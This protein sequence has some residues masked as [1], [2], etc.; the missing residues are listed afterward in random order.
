MRSR[1]RFAG[2]SAVAVAAAVVGSVALAPYS[3]AVAAKPAAST[4]PAPA[5]VVVV[6]EENHSYDDII[7]DTNDAPYINSLASQGA[8]MTSSFGV[9]H[10]SEPNYMALFAGSTFGLKSDACPVNKGNTANL[11]SELLAAGYTFKGYS[12]DLPKAGSTT[13]TSGGY[14]RKHSPWVNFSNVPGADSQPFSS[15]PTDYSTLPTVSFVIPNLNDDMHDGTI[16][17][18]DSWLQNNLANYATWAQQ[19]NSLLIVTWDEDDYTESNQ[20]PTLIT[21]AHVQPGQYSETINH[22]NLLAT[23]EQ[24]YGLA[25]VGQSSSAAPI[26]DIWN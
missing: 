22:Y 5:H 26:T 17:D 3:S 8:L 13:C 9:S 12:E 16:A 20:I 15:F 4:V 25:P 21:G 23:L 24:M 11:G 18:G 7:G 19:N 10:P 14:A 1:S 2:L 6:M